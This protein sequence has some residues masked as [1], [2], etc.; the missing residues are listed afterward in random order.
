MPCIETKLILN[1]TRYFDYLKDSPFVDVPC[2]TC[3]GCRDDLR[4]SWTTRSFY[5]WR[6]NKKSGG[7]SMFVLLTY[8]DQFLPHF[9]EY[10]DFPSHQSCFN[11]HH[12]HFFL[13][14]IRNHYRRSGVKVRHFITCEYG[15]DP[16]KT[17]RPHYHAL[18]HV[19]PGET[20]QRFLDFL[21]GMD[22]YTQYKNVRYN[23]DLQYTK[24]CGAWPYGLVSPP[25]FNYRTKQWEIKYP[26][27]LVVKNIN[28]ISYV[29]KYCTKDLN[30]Y[31]LDSVNNFKDSEFYKDHKFLLPSHFQSNGYGISIND[32]LDRFR[33]VSYDKL[34][35]VL[36]RKLPV[37][38]LDKSFSV[39]I[40]RYNINKF[41]YTTIPDGYYDSG[42]KRYRRVL[43]DL[44]VAFKKF[45]YDKVS[46]DFGE[47]IYNTLT[48]AHLRNLVSV[49]NDFRTYINLHYGKVQGASLFVD[50][51]FSD[52]D[53]SFI[54]SYTKFFT[55]RCSP[56]F[57]NIFT[58]NDLKDLYFSGLDTINF[59]Q[60]Q[61]TY[62]KS[63][64]DLFSGNFINVD[65]VPP[66]IV[67]TSPTLLPLHELK[68]LFDKYSQC[69]NALTYDKT[70]KDNLIVQRLKTDFYA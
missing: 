6:T 7:F 57:Q 34:F 55:R 2:C 68:V 61:L 63:S 5:E 70:F 50:G 56:S 60:L 31:S 4:R 47:R 19:G 36:D 29:S 23:R 42:Q 20:P 46:A 35:E 10:T 66:L 39:T 18:F 62:K 43:T 17:H 26:N 9:D 45:Q 41:L 69:L 24:H 16:D 28:A 53:I 15:E 22:T 14:R 13:E 67:D 27:D 33:S 64:S 58:Y 49:S 11:S 30:F 48:P 25:K 52:F 12:I 37:A 40:P 8:S 65:E 38:D 21:R 3:E 44:G 1:R 32:A 59:N 51:V 54:G